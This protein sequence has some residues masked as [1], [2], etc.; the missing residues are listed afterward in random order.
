MV[1]H[2]FESE[3]IVLFGTH[4]GQCWLRD[5]PLAEPTA[6]PV[7]IRSYGWRVVGQESAKRC[8]S[9]HSELNRCTIS[10]QTRTESSG[11]CEHDD[12]WDATR[13]S[14]DGRGPPIRFF[15]TL[16]SDRE[17]EYKDTTNHAPL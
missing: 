4:T 8:F 1:I 10:V 17:T 13:A 12:A 16:S 9:A 6:S 7:D 15:A 2:I 5:Q 11:A 3:F 14:V